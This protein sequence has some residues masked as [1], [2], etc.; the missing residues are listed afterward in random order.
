MAQLIAKVLYGVE[1]V[2]NKLPHPTILFIWLCLLV[3]LLSAWLAG[4]DA[5]TVHPVTG[6][7][8]EA[9]NLASGW[10]L[11]EMLSHAVSN[12]TGFAPV[13]TVIVAILGIGCAE[14]SGFIGTLLRWSVAK[15]KGSIVTMVV[16]FAGVM[17]SVAADAGYVVLIP[18]AGLVFHTM[19][20]PPLA[21]M[22]AAFAGVS[23]GFSANLVLGPIDVIL[24][25]L[26]TEALQA[27]ASLART[28]GPESNY[29]FM[30]ASVVF[31]TLLVT[32]ITERIVAP[33]FQTDEAPVEDQHAMYRRLSPR[34]GKG[35]FWALISGL[36][37]MSLFALAVVPEQ[38]ILR[39]PETGAILTSPFMSGIVVVIAVIFAAMGTAYGLATG[40]YKSGA[41]WVG[42]MEK[43]LQGLAGYLVLMFFA[44]QF[45]AWF[46]W[47]GLGPL[48]S[49]T[50]ANYLQQADWSPYLILLAFVM[51]AA[52]VNIFVGSMSAK[53]A[54]MA[55]IFVP[56][57]ALIGINPEVTQ[58]AYRIGDG[59]TNVITPLMPYFPVVLA[60][61][62]RYKSDMRIGTL[63][64]MMLP[65]SVALL[66]GW[67]V[68]LALWL[69]LGIPLGPGY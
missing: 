50:G 33:A 52:L 51:M 46:S 29:Y 37:V 21:G 44:A 64:A 7:L 63:T 68:F 15:A 36:L 22:A 32:W 31:I 24:A 27:D 48:I 5:A 8:V 40:V 16:V 61:M 2:G 14:H 3:V 23:G 35:L 10:G 56:M 20:R 53:W 38:G 25:G 9:R 28:I 69:W 42:S 26:T 30:V 60:F 57:L 11:R 4:V 13:G 19:G 39:N 55:P 47:S 49:I 43:S 34:E 18:L 41:D 58:A 67:S 59:S 62:Q 65:Y 1:A 66:I 17:S 45:V 54:V 12:F 6:E